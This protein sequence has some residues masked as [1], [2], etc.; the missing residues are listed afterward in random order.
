MARIIAGQ[1][2]VNPETILEFFNRRA[3]GVR[4]DE[5]YAVT[6]FMDKEAAE[7]RHT[8]E[9]EQILP[10]VFA[11]TVGKPQDASKEAVVLDIGCGGGRWARTLVS[12]LEHPV[13]SYCGIDFSGALIELARKQGLGPR[14]QFH[15]ARIE[16]LA[17]LTFL[18]R[19]SFSHAF[20][21]A[22]SKYMND[23]EVAKM[24]A[25][26]HNLLRPKGTIYVR[27]GVSLGE[28]RLSLIDEPSIA[29]GG[30]YNAIYRT[31]AQY[32]QLIKESGFIISHEGPLTGQNFMKHDTTGHYFFVGIKQ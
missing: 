16:A 21:V 18:G 24:L 25:A 1:P 19:H 29:L 30:D 10:L 32:R 8:S 7:L 3:I 5:H 17:T 26:A 11:S 28:A 23:E 6:T 20:A 15:C 4:S 27:E 31:C 14:A 22:V 13:Q 9:R 2:Q 12:Q